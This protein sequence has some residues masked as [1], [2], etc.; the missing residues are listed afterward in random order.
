MMTAGEAFGDCEVIG[1]GKAASREVGQLRTGDLR[2]GA[3]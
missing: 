2:A 3:E 1:R